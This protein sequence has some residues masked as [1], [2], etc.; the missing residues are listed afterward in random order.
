MSPKKS[1]RIA[2]LELSAGC[3]QEAVE[4]L[5]RLCPQ[6]QNSTHEKECTETAKYISSQVMVIQQEVA[7]LR[8]E[9]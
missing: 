7:L 3:L 1:E 8:H 5:H 9:L 2:T 6:L 4:R